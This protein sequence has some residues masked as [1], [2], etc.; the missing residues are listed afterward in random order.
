MGTLRRSSIWSDPRIKPPYRSVELDFD[1]PLAIGLI[2]AFLFNER[3]GSPRDRVTD[4]GSSPFAMSNNPGTAVW[5]TTADGSA[6]DFSQASFGY[7]KVPGLLNNSNRS[8]SS[9]YTA[10]IA[11]ITAGHYGGGTGGGT[12]DQ[13][14]WGLDN[15]GSGFQWT[16]LL[17]TVVFIDSGLVPTSEHLYSMGFGYTRGANMLFHE[18]D[19]TT[20]GVRIASINSVSTPV[21]GGSTISVI[22]CRNTQDNF[23][24]TPMLQHYFW[25]RV[26]SVADFS[27]LDLEPYVFFRPVI[28]RQYFVPPATGGKGSFFPFFVPGLLS[29]P[30]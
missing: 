24:S 20:S 13:I 7:I 15:S 12:T 22:G 16:S 1:H 17:N 18:T 4:S 9:Y 23:I 10:K 25:N 27:W 26:L 2:S 6:P 19:R 8:W 28:R 14:S 5:T 29:T 21:T 30:S 11:S 3:G